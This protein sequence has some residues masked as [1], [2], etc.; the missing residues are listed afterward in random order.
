MRLM[1]AD[2]WPVDVDEVYACW[3]WTGSHNNHGYATKWTS[4]GPEPAHVYVYE[5]EVGPVPAGLTLDHLCRRRDCVNPMHLE[6][7]KYRLNQRRKTW[8]N[9]SGH[10]GRKCPRGHDMYK[11]G[12]RTPEGGEV[13]RT[14]CGL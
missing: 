4:K 7:V 9:R 8:R 3:R 13:C 6:P 11:A 10:D 1:P 14:C 2:D 5:R 12:R